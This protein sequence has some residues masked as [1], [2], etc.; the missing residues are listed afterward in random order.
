[1]RIIVVDDEPLVR[2]GIKSSIGWQEAGMEIAGE[3]AD[4]EEALRLMEELQ[5]D[6]VLL[7]IKMPKKDGIEVLTE[8]KTRGLRSKVIVLSS[9]DDFL[10]VKQAMKLGAVD[11]FHKP[12]ME[13]G[14]VMKVLSGLQAELTLPSGGRVDFREPAAAGP[15]KEAALRALLTGQTEYAAITGI[16]EGNLHVVLF[17]VKQ[18]ADVLRRYTKESPAILPNTIRHLMGELLSH[19]KQAE[20]VQ[21]EEN[22]YAVV[23]GYSESKSVH[24]A[25]TYV[26]DTVIQIHSSLKQFLNIDTVFGLSEPFHSLRGTAQ[27]LSQARQAL[28]QRFY[29]PGEPLFYYRPQPAGQEEAYERIQAC[30]AAM[31]SGIREEKYDL[32]AGSLQEWEALVEQYECLTG[33]EVRMTYEGLLFMLQEGE[34]DA[35]TADRTEELESFADMSAY[36]HG[37]INRRL[38]AKITGPAREYNPLVRRIL[39]YLET[40]YQEAISLKGLGDLLQASPNYVS[41]IFKQE[42]G[43]GLF[44]YLNEVRIEKAK[45]LLKDPTYKIY[46]VAELVGFKSQVHFTIVFHKYMGMAPKDYRRETG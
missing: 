18:Y 12:S 21:V 41:R 17:T 6:V 45:E 44:D 11:Y 22:L 3:A 7:D 34:T 37:L 25:F 1:M 40:S 14:E 5:P 28:D 4:G 33:R 16:S 31:K 38:K 2:V 20:F 32:L 43:R 36:Y 30:T 27:A 8:M 24:A 13:I 10:H 26:N 39:Q 35:G 29:H 15:E 19:E 23:I 42:V 46:E 9:F